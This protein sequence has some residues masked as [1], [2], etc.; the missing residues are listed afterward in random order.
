MSEQAKK[1]IKEYLDALVDKEGLRTE[2][3]I[4]LTDETLWKIVA[5]LLGVGVGIVFIAHL[6]KN[7]FP[8]RQMTLNNQLLEDI[9][10]ALNP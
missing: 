5:A 3:K 10:K 8:N 6:V 2:V 7:T 9:K 4:T 1:G